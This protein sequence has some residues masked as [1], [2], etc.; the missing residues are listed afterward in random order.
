MSPTALPTM[1][2]APANTSAANASTNATSPGASPADA[3]TETGA[4]DFGLLLSDQLDILPAAEEAPAVPGAEAPVDAAAAIA[5]D[6]SSVGLQLNIPPVP[7]APISATPKRA[8]EGTATT[9]LSDSSAAANTKAESPAPART[10]VERGPAFALPTTAPVNAAESQSPQPGVALPDIK[11]VASAND[12][13]QALAAL[14]SASAAK[15]QEA[16]PVVQLAQPVGSERW[17]T[18]LGRNV[19]LLIQ[20]DQARASLHVT[21]PEMGPIEIR[22]DLSGDQASINFSVQ[23]ADTRAALENALPRL[24][25]MLGEAGINLGQSQ[26]DQRSAEQGQN[27]QSGTARHRFEDGPADESL[28]VA[29]KTR[30]GLVDTFA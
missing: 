30:V 12:S 9:L 29:V 7:A 28:A 22:I 26:I 27:Q 19:Q 25:E 8:E 23:Q 14:Q 21:P 2:A 16:A 4:Q 24:R 18:E 3:S 13:T 11:P 1:N 5:V 10:P 6:P 17:N 15:P 20:G